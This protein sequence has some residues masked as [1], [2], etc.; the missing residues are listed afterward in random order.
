MS[1]SC[2][3]SWKG[4]ASGMTRR[5]GNIPARFFGEGVA[6]ALHL[7]R[8]HWPLRRTVID[9]GKQQVFVRLMVP[10]RATWSH[11]DDVFDGGFGEREGLLLLSRWALRRREVVCLCFKVLARWWQ[12]RGR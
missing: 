12:D 3:C 7:S 9:D 10:D 1:S 5:R 11:C 6:F 2:N 4:S 8:D